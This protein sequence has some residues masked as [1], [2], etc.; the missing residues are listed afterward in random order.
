MPALG[1]KLSRHPAITVA[2]IIAGKADHRLSQGILIVTVNLLTALHRAV[3]SQN[4]TGKPFRDTEPLL[5]M[6]DTP[7]A[8][9]G[10]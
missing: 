3:L 8:A 10:A 5:D 2:A 6:D 4:P 1:L 9:L 7:P